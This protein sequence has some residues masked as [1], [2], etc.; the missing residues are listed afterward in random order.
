MRAIALR[1]EPAKGVMMRTSS[2]RTDDAVEAAE[3][4]T[5]VADSEG[6]SVFPEECHVLLHPVSERAGRTQRR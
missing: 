5:K 2:L 1:M 3:L 6:A 4:C